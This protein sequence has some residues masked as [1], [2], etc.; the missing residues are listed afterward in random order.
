MS[1]TRRVLALVRQQ[2]GL[3]DME[4][5]LRLFGSAAEPRLTRLACRRLELRRLVE[6]D[7]AATPIRNFPRQVPV[8]DWGNQ[9]G[10]GFGW[11]GA[12]TER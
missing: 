4:I 10:V 3:A 12:G 2:A 8:P 7:R 6:R 1:L 9:A 11:S 5:A